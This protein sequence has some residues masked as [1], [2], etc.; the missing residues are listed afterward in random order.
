M[1]SGK[2]V[3]PRRVTHNVFATPC[4]CELGD[5]RPSL[6]TPFPPRPALPLIPSRKREGRQSRPLPLWGRVGERVGVLC[7]ETRFIGLWFTP[8]AFDFRQHD[9]ALFALGH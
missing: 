5:N 7:G 3:L 4:F 2:K 8:D 6:P 1:V 9:A